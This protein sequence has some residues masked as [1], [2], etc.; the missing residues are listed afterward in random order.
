[1]A[2]GQVF[3]VTISHLPN[4]PEGNMQAHGQVDTHRILSKEMPSLSLPSAPAYLQTHEPFSR[5][6]ELHTGVV[7]G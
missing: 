1:M 2:V 6:L 4:K 3:M 7:P 5:C